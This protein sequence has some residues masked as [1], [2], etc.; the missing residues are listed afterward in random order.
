M[1]NSKQLSLHKS[2]K[3]SLKRVSC[4]F[5]A[6]SDIVINQQGVTADSLSKEYENSQEVSYITFVMSV[7]DFGIGIP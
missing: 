7:Q 1:Q 5:L 3:D 6:K 2:T 4:A